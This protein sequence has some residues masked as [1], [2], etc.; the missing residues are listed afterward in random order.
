MPGQGACLLSVPPP[1]K[2]ALAIDRDRCTQETLPTGEGLYQSGRRQAAKPAG[3]NPKFCGA[4]FPVGFWKTA[5]GSGDSG[6]HRE[7]D[8]LSHASLWGGAGL[9]GSER[10]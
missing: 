8:L 6:K 5:G 4:G 7:A 2:G 9:C 1:I 3:K 10:G